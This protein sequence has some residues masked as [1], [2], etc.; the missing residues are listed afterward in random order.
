MLRGLVPVC[1]VIFPLPY[2]LVRVRLSVDIFL[3]SPCF[4]TKAGFFKKKKEGREKSPRNFSECAGYNLLLRCIHFFFFFS[5]HREDGTWTLVLPSHFS[6]V[7]DI[8]SCRSLF[9]FLFF[10]SCFPIMTR[11]LK[12]SV[13]EGVCAVRIS[14]FHWHCHHFSIHCFIVLFVVC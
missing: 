9:V 3:C 4:R 14:R 11:S 12:K 6:F 1:L 8:R 5:L 13:V 2:S 10:F 7:C